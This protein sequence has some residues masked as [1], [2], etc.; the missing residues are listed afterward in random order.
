MYKPTA[1]PI[2][3]NPAASSKNEPVVKK[4]TEIKSKSNKNSFL[5]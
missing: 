3:K 5:R 1:M 4:K 2:A